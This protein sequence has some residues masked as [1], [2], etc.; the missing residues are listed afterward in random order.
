LF[1]LI[2]GAMG[3]A[4]GKNIRRQPK[5]AMAVHALIWIAGYAWYWARI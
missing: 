4:F 2:A 5:V 3:A 1:W